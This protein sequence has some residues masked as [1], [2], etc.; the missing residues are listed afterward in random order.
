M[1][2]P[3]DP[4]GSP[5]PEA[6]PNPDPAGQG[7][8]PGGPGR[9]DRE[10]SAGPPPRGEGGAGDP[11]SS[12]A[13]E[14]ASRNPF[15]GAAWN[16]T[17]LL[18]AQSVDWQRGVRAPVEAY[19]RRGEDEPGDG[20]LILNLVYHEVLLRRRINGEEPTLEE[21]AARFPHL[22]DELR[23]QFALDAA[24]PF[25]ETETSGLPPAGVPPAPADVPGYEIFEVL[26]RG[27]TGVVYRAR[28]RS[29]NRPVALKMI[30]DGSHSGARQAGRFRA[31][32]EAI[33]RLQ[34]P[35]IV[36][37]HEVGEH[38][39]RPFLALEYVPGGTLDRA[40]GGTPLPADRAA[41]LAEPLA[42]A[43]EHAH[44]RGVVHRD[45]K[46]ANVL[47]TAAGEPKIA[48]F[49]LARIV[50]G[51]SNQTDSG[52]MVGTPSYMAPEQVDGGPGRVGPAADIYALGAIL[53]E[54]LTGR[55]P[56]RGESPVETLL[57]VRG[58]DVVP[59]RRL[60]PDLPRDL[61]TIC[62]KCLEKDPRRRY[63]TARALADDL[64]AFRD[65]R[66]IVAR[67]VP[68]WER[69]WLWARRQRGAAAGL[70]LG[71]LALLALL[72]GGVVHN[73]VLSRLNAKLERTNRELIDARAGA[74]ENAR[75]ALAA[76]S[77]LLVRVADERL[78]GVPEA[79][80]VRRELLRDA[81][82]RLG[83]LQRRSPSDPGARLEMGR[84]HL[85]IAAIHAALG[86]YARS[87]EQFRE[88]IGILE[89][90][91]AG[92]GASAPIRDEVARAHLGLAD[93][94]PP[95]EGRPHFL[96]AVELWEPAAE[97]D[98]A[99]RGRLA[100]AYLSVASSKDGFGIAPGASYCEKAVAMLEGLF[101]DAPEA[102]RSDLARAHHNLGLAEGRAGRV[103]GAIEHYRRA[104]G[105]WRAIPADRRPDVDQEALATCQNA[106]GLAL[107]ARPG[108]TEA[109]LKEA[110]GLLREAVG[111]DRELV[112]RHPRLVKPRIGLAQAWSNLGS[113]YWFARRWREAEE[114][115]ASALRAAE[116][117]ARDFPENRGLQVLLAHGHGD[118][119]DARSKLGRIDE[120][121]AGFGRALAIVEP[122]VAASPGDSGAQKCL[123]VVLLNEANTV[124]AVSGSAAAL[125]SRERSVR[126]LEAAHRLAPGDGEAAYILRGSR[127]NL[128]GTLAAL[129][130]HDEA[131]VQFDALIRDADEAARPPLML[132]RALLLARAGRHAEALAAARP[133][134]DRPGPDGESSYNLAC[135]FGLIAASA[136]K[137]P[138][139][140]SPRKDDVV[141]ECRR[142][143]LSLLDRAAADDKFPRKELLDLLANDAD[144]DA[145]RATPEFAA[146]R[147]RL[148]P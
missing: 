140:P 107:Q 134:A 34:H 68:A 54:A 32:A 92:H 110:E 100:A 105:L 52:A 41:A 113:F 23:E 118:L 61:E 120:A 17:L 59:P 37:I 127:S 104:E 38:E 39:G 7:R 123:G 15:G 12:S 101:R 106:L 89:G 63:A 111:S 95:A 8:G 40:L 143:A 148:G 93:L 16:L 72:A 132:Q 69:A 88:A 44:G 112:R 125:P 28:Q 99:A 66:P 30:L 135:A 27:G 78:A 46:P 82:D 136:G 62:L 65:G 55:P 58:A 115:Y 85:G 33:A 75:D 5:P 3:E 87:R 108:A 141:A 90:L 137:D 91:L 122:I 94:L 57:Q 53:Y 71:A 119:A 77:Q 74:E 96:R 9:A 130:R 146:L 20:E 60:R 117:A 31:E 144:L 116:E 36:Q 79:E 48:D 81:I 51:D 142:R 24:L 21:Y 129:G 121:R 126:A 147:K 14:G 73:L 4:P 86:E 1:A 109:D 139:L 19:L 50:A 25:E 131:L 56:F 145:I 29:L 83:P 124:A 84:A 80:P 103:A 97:S 18:D 67:P 10:P 49:G 11:P 70:A 45:L 133:L 114:A 76:I 13:G 138:S 42:L 98:P 102:Y 43:V 64:R 47:L 128:A 22:A 26:G 35:G 6:P 2:T